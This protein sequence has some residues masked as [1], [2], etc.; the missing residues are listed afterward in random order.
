M[1]CPVQVIVADVDT[2]KAQA[3]ADGLG[4]NVSTA[5]VDDVNA[6]V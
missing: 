3:V 2:A 4:G 1:C 5:S 6:G